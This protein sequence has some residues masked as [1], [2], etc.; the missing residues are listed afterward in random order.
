VLARRAEVGNAASDL[1]A[2]LFTLRLQQGRVAELLPSM[3]PLVD[4]REASPTWRAALALARL[5]GGEQDA[6]REDFDA[7]AE[8]NFAAVPHDW[9][10]FMT[11]ALLAESCTRLGDA[12]RAARLYE[13]LA[14][15][16]DRYVQVV[17]MLS[18]GSVQRHLGLL[19]AAMDRLD[20][21]EEHF[22]AALQANERI[23]SERW[24][25]RLRFRATWGGSPSVRAL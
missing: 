8:D 10:W 20:D 6:G 7:M 22:E 23:G 14:P 17:Y 12:Q 15:F 18:W 1:M 25:S 3:K 24:R 9:F 21:A 11:M 2:M 4:I 5:E 19:A 16:A 13:M